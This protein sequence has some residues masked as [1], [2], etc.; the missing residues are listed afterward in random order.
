MKNLTRL[1]LLAEQLRSIDAFLWERR[2]GCEEKEWTKDPAHG[3]RYRTLTS[4]PL[5]R[6][7]ICEH[8]A[9]FAE[10]M[11]DVEIKT[12]ALA[13]GHAIP[14]RYHKKSDS[15]V[16]CIHPQRQQYVELEWDGRRRSTSLTLARMISIP[17]TM[18]HGFRNKHPHP[19]RLITLS[20][21]PIAEDDTFYT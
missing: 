17:K 19:L 15:V 1:H 3:L 5:I 16:L 7:R 11:K 4:H 20:S 10:L 8:D 18:V 2:F 12:L 13:C 14:D 21:P 9:Q 6:A